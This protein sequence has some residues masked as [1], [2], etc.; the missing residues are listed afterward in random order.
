[1]TSLCSAFGA[2][3]LLFAHGAGA[4]NRQPIGA[5]V[6]YGVLISMVLTL[7]VVPAV[8]ALVAR[9]TRSPRYWTRIIETHA[10]TSQ[11]CQ[12]PVTSP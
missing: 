5:A 2:I 4:E 11:A 10:Q 8:Y 1:M 6:L 7:V 12:A 3:P 9:N